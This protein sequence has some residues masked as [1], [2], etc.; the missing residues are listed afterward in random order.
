[1]NEYEWMSKNNAHKYTEQSNDN[2]DNNGITGGRRAN[3]INTKKNM[4]LDR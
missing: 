3:E 4:S 2:N 1:M